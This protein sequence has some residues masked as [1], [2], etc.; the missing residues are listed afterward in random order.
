MVP[1]NTC[2]NPRHHEFPNAQYHFRPIPEFAIVRGS[3]P[4]N[5]QAF[6][7]AHATARQEEQDTIQ[8]SVH[9]LSTSEHRLGKGR[10]T[11]QCQ[12][13]SPRRTN[14]HSPSHRTTAAADGTSPPPAKGK[15]AMG[16]DPTTTTKTKRHPPM[17]YLPSTAV[18]EKRSRKEQ[19]LGQRALTGADLLILRPGTDLPLLPPH[20][21]PL[22]TR[23]GQSRALNAAAA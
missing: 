16:A 5:N 21:R 22:L 15:K 3:V 6:G 17:I 12:R 8:L 1:A 4:G 7:L 14:L 2:I 20:R 10:I 9:I 18:R 11:P 23:S 13:G 19:G